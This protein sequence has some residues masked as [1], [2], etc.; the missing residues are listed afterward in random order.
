MPGQGISYEIW[1][2]PAQGT[3]RG[4]KLVLDVLGNCVGTLRACD[5]SSY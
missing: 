1:Q 3:P 2:R 4:R 5:E